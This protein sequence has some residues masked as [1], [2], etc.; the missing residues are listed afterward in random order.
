MFRPI[1]AMGKK[2]SQ[3][4]LYNIK[5][6]MTQTKGVVP[7]KYYNKAGFTYCTVSSYM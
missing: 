5:S 4:L 2:V 7:L 3:A 1:S 6:Y